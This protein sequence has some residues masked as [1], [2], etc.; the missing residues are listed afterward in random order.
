[1]IHL[2]FLWMLL[3]MVIDAC[4]VYSTW[5]VRAVI[6]FL[7]AILF[8]ITPTHEVGHFWKLP[9]RPTTP[10]RAASREVAPAAAASPPGAQAS[11]VPTPTVPGPPATEGLTMAPMDRTVQDI[12]F[13][14]LESR[15]EQI[16]EGP[17]VIVAASG[18]GSRAA[19]FTALV[20]EGLR[21][22][23]D[24]FRGLRSQSHAPNGSSRSAS[25]RPMLADR[26]L[27]VSSVS[28]GSLATAYYLHQNFPHVR[29]YRDREQST[30]EPPVVSVPRQA[31]PRKGWR[32][33]YVG[34]VHARMRT[35]SLAMLDDARS[36]RSNVFT[37]RTGRTFLETLERVSDECNRLASGQRADPSIAPWLSGS[38][39]VDDMSTDFT[40]ALIRGVLLPGVE[41][42]ESVSRFWEDRFEWANIEDLDLH[43]ELDPNA[44]LDHTQPRSIPN[45]LSPLALFNAC[46][47]TRGARIVLGFPPLPRGLIADSLVS[48]TSNG[49]YSLTDR[50]DFYYHVT[51]AEAV[52]LSANFPW[53]FETA[54]LSLKGGT[55]TVLVL[56]G[57]IVDNSGIDSISYLLQGLDRHA[58]VY[59]SCR[60]VGRASSLDARAARFMENL[61]QR[62]VILIQIDSG[63]KDI[64]AG[65]P[66]IFSLLAQFV[67]VFF[68]PVQALNNTSYTNADLAILAH[69]RALQRLLTPKIASEAI[70]FPRG[71]LDAGE[72]PPVYRRVRLTCNN[73]QN[74]MTAWTLGPEDKA[75]VMVQFL[76]EWA[77]QKRVLEVASE[78]VNETSIAYQRLRTALEESPPAERRQQIRE[79]VNSLE[80]LA[81][82]FHVFQIGQGYDDRGRAN[83]YRG[84]TDE[85]TAANGALAR[86]QVINDL[87]DLYWS[88][89]RAEPGPASGPSPRN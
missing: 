18:G 89:Y 48:A 27:L 14:A 12:W 16:P 85:S 23:P 60:D 86:P 50:G 46:D 34:D 84:E 32:N 54:R 80:A 36:G 4:H 19:L 88:T 73:Q 52:R 55:E 2:I 78:R 7:A 45:R 74:V 26:I 76:I 40:A 77:N 20:L 66:T 6:A 5:N 58:E 56:D 81:A 59:R 31:I 63:A 38:S 79:S 64:E 42:G 49:P 53:G 87:L 70:A 11:P 28:G 22:M 69:D 71:K 82:D 1:M 3:A 39:F 13:W 75:R 51:L 33:S 37:A 43:R 62:G 8:A 25:E 41:R 67:P 44:P 35:I 65:G 72:L 30:G 24:P 15:I 47:V 61:R 9:P 83:F 68:R 10:G 29:A 57:G 21:D 17:V